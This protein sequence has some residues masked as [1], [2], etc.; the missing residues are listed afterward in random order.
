MDNLEKI[1]DE[2]VI[3]ASK[4]HIETDPFIYNTQF[5]T[6]YGNSE[7]TGNKLCLKIRD[8]QQFLS[9]ISKY[10]LQLKKYRNIDFDY[11]TIKEAITLL[12][13]NLTYEELTK[14]ESYIERYI[15]FYDNI[16]PNAELKKFSSFNADTTFLRK[17]KERSKQLNEIEDEKTANIAKR[18]YLEG[19][20]GSQK[21]NNELWDSNITISNNIQSLNQETPYVCEIKFNKEVDGQIVSFTLPRISYGINDGICYIYAVQNKNEVKEM[22]SLEKKYQSIINRS[23]YELNDGV[24]ENET[25]EYKDYKE[26]KTKEYPENISDVSPSSIFALAIFLNILKANN[27]NMVKVVSFLPIRYNA[28]EKANY[29]KVQFVSKKQELDFME[30]VA[31]F[32]KLKIEQ[33]MIQDNL[34]NKFIRNFMRLKYHFNNINI[35]NIP[36]ES[37]EVVSLEIK[38]F[39]SSNNEIL[40]EIIEKIGEISHDK[41]L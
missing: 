21:R 19:L 2:F 16:L 20:L 27:I 26:G 10:L 8:K 6:V 18:E 11:N 3:E 12:F 37:E 40:N 9:L 14:P 24:Y 38:D 41:N 13:S 22:N 36:F 17:N 1:F 15:S 30:K 28:K 23:L 7:Y 5:Q 33:N 25:Q 32:K 35:L 31:L 34:T 39:E 29:K 4:G